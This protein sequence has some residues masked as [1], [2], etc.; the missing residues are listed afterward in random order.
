MQRRPVQLTFVNITDG[1]LGDARF[2]AL[3]ESRTISQSQLDAVES[4]ES[5]SNEA[6]EVENAPE[7]QDGCSHAVRSLV[8][9]I[10]EELEKIVGRTPTDSQHRAQPFP[11]G[12]FLP[13]WRLWLCIV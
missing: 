5:G 13:S 7:P 11:V 4:M 2:A 1:V 3:L 12:I 9:Y 6:D 10:F 8:T